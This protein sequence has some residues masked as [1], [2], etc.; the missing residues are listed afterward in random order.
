MTKLFDVIFLEEALAF[1]ESLE[2]KHA[3]KIFY[4]IRH[5]QIERDPELFKKLTAEIWE[6][7]TLYQGMQY[8]LL[9]FWDKSD[10]RNTLVISTHGFV[11]KRSEVPEKE[12]QKALKLR[13]KYFEEK[14]S[15]KKRK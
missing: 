15:V 9:A 11:K 14:E 5:A 4:N 3:D 2:E 1:I 6:F 8:R 13:E 10:N 7:R 12:I